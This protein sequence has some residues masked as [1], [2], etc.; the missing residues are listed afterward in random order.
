MRLYIE[1]CEATIADIQDASFKLDTRDHIIK[2][3]HLSPICL[4]CYETVFL[5]FKGTTKKRKG[6]PESTQV[7]SFNNKVICLLDYCNKI[8]INGYMITSYYY[9][10]PCNAFFLLCANL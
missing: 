8:D 10:P 9:K 3:V 6:V 1:T 5:F 7:E 4:S 2:F